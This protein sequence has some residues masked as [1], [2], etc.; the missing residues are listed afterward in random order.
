MQNHY[1]SSKQK[2]KKSKY[3]THKGIG[4][5]NIANDRTVNRYK[6]TQG[7]GEGAKTGLMTIMPDAV[8]KTRTSNRVT[9]LLML[10][11]RCIQA[12][13]LIKGFL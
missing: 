12:V 3:R 7:P 10:D 6:H 11:P 1:C 4:M 9:L 8:R 2:Q 13:S 5:P